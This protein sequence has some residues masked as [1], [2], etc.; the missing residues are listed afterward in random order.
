MID[1]EI[2]IEWMT[3]LLVML[4]VVWNMLGG[5]IPLTHARSSFAV[6]WDGVKKPHF[7]DLAPADW[8]ELDADGNY[9][10]P[11][12]KV[13]DATGIGMPY[14][15]PVTWR[16]PEAH[17][18]FGSER[19]DQHVE[20]ILRKEAHPQ[21]ACQV[22]RMVI[23]RP[24]SLGESKIA[25]SA[26]W[27]WIYATQVLGA[28]FV[29]GEATILADDYYGPKYTNQFLGNPALGINDIATAA[30]IDPHV[31]DGE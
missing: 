5:L 10:N 14:K 22:A 27:S 21:W 17:P 6:L 13:D 2:L 8:D 15:N 18:F 25:E 31:E 30:P 19:W 4:T 24:W 29:T 7:W 9:V 20:V 23:C 26:E 1:I 12:R 16:Q 28:R 3:P 11:S